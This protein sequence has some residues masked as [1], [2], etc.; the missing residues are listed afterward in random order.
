[1]SRKPPIHRKG[2]GWVYR[3]RVI[4]ANGKVRRPTSPIYPTATA[5]TV[6]WTKAKPAL[7]ALR[8]Q[9]V[10][11]RGPLM[12]LSTIAEQ[13]AA[14]GRLRRAPLGECYIYMVIDCM[15]GFAKDPGWTV[16]TDITPKKL[17]AWVLACKGVNVFH[18]LSYL[19]SVL[20]YG[21][22]FLDQPV[23]PG[24]Y[25]FTAPGRRRTDPPPLLTDEEVASVV[26]V[27]EDLGPHLGYLVRHLATYGCR[28][29]DLVRANVADFDPVE[30]ILTLRDTKNGTTGVHAL[31]PED[32][33]ILRELTAGR[34]PTDPLLL[35]PDGERW[36]LNKRF[37]A[38]KLYKWYASRAAGH[39]P[40]GR[41]SIYMLKDYFI[42]RSR[43]AGV[44]P[45][46]VADMANQRDLRSQNY[47]IASN[48]LL[49]RQALQMVPRIGGQPRGQS[50]EG[51]ISGASRATPDESICYG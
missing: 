8:A 1:M 49:Q 35:S 47:Y 38:E 30:G 32:A 48:L 3:W 43:L 11:T 14:A 9:R 17:Q 7:D 50:A 34:A 2:D 24:V 6:A 36:P 18:R 45:R 46:T 37:Y 51:A 25:D 39:L 26:A 5:A 22:K 42:S 31:H 19:K 29:I 15:R 21:E 44:D 33:D 13:W 41:R 10:R 40:Q 23:M 27:A 12:T 20:R 28:P 16:S 4:G